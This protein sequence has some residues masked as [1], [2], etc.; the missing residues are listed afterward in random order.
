MSNQCKMS[1][2]IF[3]AVLIS[4]SCMGVTLTGSDDTV[5][6]TATAEKT[7]INFSENVIVTINYEPQDI[8][9]ASIS[10]T[11][12]ALD[13]NIIDEAA[14]YLKAVIVPSRPGEFETLLKF[15]YKDKD[16][17]EAVFGIGQLNLN[18][19]TNLTEE[20]IKNLQSGD[21][22]SIVDPIARTEKVESVPVD[23]TILIAACIGI[24]I[25]AGGFIFAMRKKR[26]VVQEQKKY[27]VLHNVAYQLL[28]DLKFKN[29]PDL[30]KFKLYYS[31]LSNILR[32]YIEYRFD[33]QA[34]DMTTEEF[35]EH[36][37][38]SD[39]LASADRSS[40]EKFFQI[41]DMVKFAKFQPSTEQAFEALESVRSFLSDTEDYLCVIE[42]SIADKYAGI[43]EG[44]DDTV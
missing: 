40:I 34:P 42:Q 19:A 32:Y 24:L 18:V 4:I 28:D 44:D 37:R 33:I 26:K 7:D 25:L 43:L 15:E 35:L 38:Y 1:T 31:S 20:D 36:I 11:D 29:L 6:A 10:L 3:L 41:C 27:V 14:G 2:T 39:S 13:V 8:R 21:I 16:D 23:P 12:E 9:D 30:G 22:S 5:K 17:V